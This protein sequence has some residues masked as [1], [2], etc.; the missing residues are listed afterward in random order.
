[1]RKQCNKCKCS[2]CK[3]RENKICLICE[4]CYDFKPV[5]CQDFWNKD[6]IS[7]L[8]N[9]EFIA[10]GVQRRI[11]DTKKNTILKI[12]INQEGLQA[13]LEEITIYKDLQQYSNVDQLV[14]KVGEIISYHPQGYWIEMIKYND[15]T[16]N[17]IIEKFNELID[18]IPIIDVN[19]SNLGKDEYGN[20]VLMDYEGLHWTWFDKRENP[21]YKSSES[22]RG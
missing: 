9:L 19:Y 21:Y 14:I 11:Y 2:N 8:E 18:V 3:V 5:K 10:T 4:C 20:Y 6:D 22:L 13:N 7:I 12:P 15:K 1:M 17:D 16:T